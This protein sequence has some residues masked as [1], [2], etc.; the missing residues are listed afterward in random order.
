[1]PKS[2]SLGSRA[3]HQDV[4]R[5]EVAMHHE[6]GVCVGHGCDDLAHQRDP[7]AR[8]W[9]LRF[10]PAIEAL[11]I[12]E[13][14]GEKGIAFSVV[15]AIDQVGDVGVVERREDAAFALKATQVLHAPV[16]V[17]DLFQRDKLARIAQFALGQPDH[18]HA[19]ASHFA[20][21]AVLGQLRWCGCCR[22]DREGAAAAQPHRAGDANLRRAA[23]TRA[24][25]PPGASCAHWVR[26]RAVRGRPA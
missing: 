2:S 3:R 13:L 25:I 1:M 17:R 5:F 4:G 8:A 11:A 21:D 15:A 24:R 23:V 14:G 18:A 7:R 6:L 10:A 26:D 12:D 19:A 22:R 9:R 16:R 20:Q